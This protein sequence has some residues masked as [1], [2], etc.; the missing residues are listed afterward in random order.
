MHDFASTIWDELKRYINTVDRLE[1]AETMVNVMI[2]NDIDVD[3]IRSE[4]KGDAD[5]RRA[6][7][8]YLDN[9][10]DDAADDEDLDDSEYFMDQDEDE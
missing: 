9:D 2:D 6:L 4:F 10:K 7:N 1:A 5:I 3:D 8:A